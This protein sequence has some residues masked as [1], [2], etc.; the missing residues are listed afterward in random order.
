MRI[1]GDRQSRHPGR[2]GPGAEPREQPLMAAVNSVEVADRDDGP[3]GYFGDLAGPVNRDHP[4]RSPAAQFHGFARPIQRPFMEGGR[5]TLSPPA[6]K[7]VN[8]APEDR[9]P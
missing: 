2:V 7:A 9:R 4:R 1:K 5:K 8:P 3:A 6:V